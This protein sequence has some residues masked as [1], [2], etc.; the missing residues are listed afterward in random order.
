M[1]GRLQWRLDDFQPPQTV[2]HSA[3]SNSWFSADC[4]WRAGET[5]TTPR[6]GAFLLIGLHHIPFYRA[7][8][9]RRPF[10][11]PVGQ[12]TKIL[13]AR[14][15]SLRLFSRWGN[16]CS[17]VVPREG[18]VKLRSHRSSCY[19]CAYRNCLANIE[20]ASV[21]SRFW[22]R[23]RGKAQSLKHRNFIMLGRGVLS[24]IALISPFRTKTRQDI[25]LLN[26]DQQK[27][28]PRLIGSR[29]TAAIAVVVTGYVA[30]L[31]LRAAFWQSPHH[32]HW[33]LPVGTFWP[34][35]ATL[36]A[37][38]AF[39]AYLVW[40]CVVFPRALPGKERV[41]AI[42]WA[43]SLLLSLIQ[44][45]VSA[46]LAAFIQYVRAASIMVAL[47]AAVSILIEGSVGGDSARDSNIPE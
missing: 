9:S 38:L 37:N 34:A 40:L 31:T 19:R 41:L 26:V 32:F 22:R 2:L 45:L 29:F 25:I 35:W 1:E 27:R 11:R 39:Y 33:P 43:L 10:R 18:P 21:R 28:W 12:R 30:A 7:G 8:A 13:E 15:D 36:A 24:V 3:V 42:G 4:Y 46:S 5:V 20:I 6:T 23:D 44:G 14:S 16:S 47:F 17:R